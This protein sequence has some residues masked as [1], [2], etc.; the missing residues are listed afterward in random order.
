MIN[1]PDD[2]ISITL[3][4]ALF[5]ETLYFYSEFLKFNLLHEKNLPD[6]KRVA[7][8][9]I[10]DNVGFRIVLISSIENAEE[11]F[12]FSIN[13]NKSDCEK[14]FRQM[15]SENVFFLKDFTSFPHMNYFVCKDP[16]GN[17]VEVSEFFPD[18]IDWDR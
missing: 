13:I 4:T 17:V 12:K 9:Q 8:L 6:G 15:K 18:M 11:G 5:N 3:N 7:L 10:G 2:L 14:I 1:Y 16:A